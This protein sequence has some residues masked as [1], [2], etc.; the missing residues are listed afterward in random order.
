[1][2]KSNYSSLKV[3]A[4]ILVCALFSFG[5]NTNRID[6]TKTHVYLAFVKSDGENI[7]LSFHNNSNGAVKI[8]VRN[9]IPFPLLQKNIINGEETYTLKNELEYKLCY[10]VE[11]YLSNIAIPTNTSKKESLKKFK[12]ARKK[13]DCDSK[14]IDFYVNDNQNFKQW[15]ASDKSVTFNVP[16]KYLQEAQGIYVT[17]EYDW[18]ESE[19]SPEYREPEH[20]AEFFGFQL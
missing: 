18:E 1:M 3:L 15:I 8:C 7:T 20:R 16:A 12:S 10:G 2:L 19:Y 13:S 17:Y 14:Q 4:L 5:Q 6:D 11:T 9:Y